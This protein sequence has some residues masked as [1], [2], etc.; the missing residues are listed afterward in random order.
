MAVLPPNVTLRDRPGA[1]SS[2]QL[3]LAMA[4]TGSRQAAIAPTERTQMMG[5]VRESLREAEMTS[6]TA[7]NLA[8]EMVL[9]R[10][11]GIKKMAGVTD[12]AQALLSLGASTPEEVMAKIGM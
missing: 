4:Q 2:H 12:G 7:Q 8:N 5:G 9:N 6:G 1:P 10:I 3:N 11:T